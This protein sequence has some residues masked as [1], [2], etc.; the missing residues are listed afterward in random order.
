MLLQLQDL[1]ATRIC[2]SA[3]FWSDAFAME[4]RVRIKWLFD[5]QQ[6]D[7]CRPSCLPILGEWEHA[8]GNLLVHSPL[9][10]PQLD[11]R[12]VLNYRKWFRTVSNLVLNIYEDRHFTTCSHLRSS[13]T[14][15]C[16]FS[17]F[18]VFQIV[19]VASSV[20]GNYQEEYGSAFLL[21]PRVFIM[22]LSEPPEPS[23]LQ[24]EQ[25]QFSQFLLIYRT[26]WNNLSVERDPQWPS[27]PTAW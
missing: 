3:R 10:P 17:G 27:S 26:K 25:S 12:L 23:L 2:K 6:L 20:T 1:P 21:P 24:T 14:Q 15:K 13:S 9:L 22:H 18:P 4:S 11:Q 7:I 5:I 8:S 16:A 19:P